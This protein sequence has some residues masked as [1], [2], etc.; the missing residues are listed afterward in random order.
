MASHF[1]PEEVETE[2]VAAM[3]KSLGKLF[4]TLLNETAWLHHQWHQFDVLFATKSERIAL[5]NE[6][7]PTF[8]RLVQ[9]NFW[10]QT[11]LHLC[12]LTDPVATG[13]KENLTIRRL[14]PEVAPA[15]R[16]DLQILADSAVQATEFAR[17]WRNRHIA[18]N[19][20]L[21][22]MNPGARPLASASHAQVRYAIDAIT[23]VLQKVGEHYTKSTLA[24]GPGIADPGNAEELL[25]V[26]RDG[27]RAVRAREQRIAEG[28]WLED[29]LNQGTV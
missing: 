5:L 11:L 25:Y 18:H 14:T 2:Y 29:D 24:F 21:L 9:D 20:W 17:D 16:A 10:E 3:G 4:F 8:F 7:A 28:K 12:R 19:D 1:T 23:A 15:I 27:V 6:A 26:L 22:A 13:T